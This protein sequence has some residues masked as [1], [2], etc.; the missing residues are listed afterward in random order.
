V[1]R[2]EYDDIIEYRE[3]M[4]DKII[5][6]PE[7]QYHIKEVEHLVPQNY[8]QDYYV[9]KY[10]EAPVSQIQSRAGRAGASCWSI[11]WAARRQ[12]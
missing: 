1:E 3:V 6:V 12:L 7:V 5:E 10:V 11:L 8:V 4:V 2:I 9:D